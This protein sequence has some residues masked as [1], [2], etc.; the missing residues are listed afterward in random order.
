MAMNLWHGWHEQQVTQVRGR[1]EQQ[2]QPVAPVSPAA[3]RAGEARRGEGTSS[4]MKGRRWHAVGQCMFR[5]EQQRP[6]AWQAAVDMHRRQAQQCPKARG[7]GGGGA[8]VDNAEGRLRHVPR[9]DVAIARGGQGG[10]GPVQSVDVPAHTR[11]EG[12]YR[13]PR[14]PARPNSRRARA[15]CQARGQCTALR[16]S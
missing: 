3:G 15:A 12:V 9:V 7:G 13:Q 2:Q 10:H 11:Q 5:T 8:Q 4:S 16:S 1:C 6:E 14:A